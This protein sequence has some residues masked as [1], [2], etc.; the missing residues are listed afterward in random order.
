MRDEE[1]R[2]VEA[3]EQ[4]VQ[5]RA[6]G[7]LRMGVEGRERLVEEQHLRVAGERARKRDPL[8]L[9]ARK[10]TGARGFEV[11]DA[12]SL[13]VFVGRVPAGVLDVLAHGQVREERVLLEDQADAPAFGRHVDVALAVEEDVVVDRDA[14]RPWTREACD[15]AQDGRLAGAGRSDE[16]ERRGGLEAQL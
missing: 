7:S 15:R 9:A 3:R 11:G 1:H 10:P 5:L 8:S 6:H 16:R 14:S 4:I 13:E 2:D 12:K